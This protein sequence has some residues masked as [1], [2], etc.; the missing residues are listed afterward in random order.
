MQVK[1][2]EKENARVQEEDEDPQR[3]DRPKKTTSKGAPQAYRMTSGERFPKSDRLVKAKDFRVVYN[4]GAS[5]KKW[6][7]I[8]CIAPNDTGCNRIGIAIASRNIKHAVRR[9][10][11][12]RLL[13]EA[14]RKS[15]K[16]LKKGHDL[17]VVVKR[18]PGELFGYKEAE[19]TLLK[20]VKLAKLA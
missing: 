16:L 9:N 1:Y 18:D 5:F 13:R 4:K 3:K 20:L 2:Q 15:N 14:Y 11:I 12:K 7:F 6:P 10:R 8:L 19:S 17:V